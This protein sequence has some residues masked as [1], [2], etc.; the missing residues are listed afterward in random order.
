MVV[1]G[2]GVLVA[3]ALDGWDCDGSGREK[4]E[5]PDIVK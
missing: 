4:E 1:K 3:L 5:T 2:G